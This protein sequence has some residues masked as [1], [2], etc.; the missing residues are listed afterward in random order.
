M[1]VSLQG[2]IYRAK[3]NRATDGFLVLRPSGTGWPVWTPVGASGPK[4]YSW[5]EPNLGQSCITT[6]EISPLCATCIQTL[7]QAKSTPG[8]NSEGWA[9]S[10]QAHSFSSTGIA[11]ESLG[12]L[13]KYSIDK[14][15]NA[16]LDTA[17][18]CCCDCRDHMAEKSLRMG[19]IPWPM[20]NEHLQQ[21]CFSSK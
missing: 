12:T 15:L 16:E 13:H 8:N 4:A 11:W 19:Q 9:S 14:T 1:A 10:V 7:S 3:Q 2:Y 17:H 20:Q 18:W 6:C 5:R 21:L